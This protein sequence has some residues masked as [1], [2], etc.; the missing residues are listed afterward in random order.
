[1]SNGLYQHS[2]GQRLCLWK[3][4]GLAKMR[5]V[6][7]L[8]SLGDSETIAKVKL[9]NLVGSHEHNNL[10]SVLCSLPTVYC[11]LP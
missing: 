11:L 10:S 6:R 8:V 2:Q 3:R 4:W 9:W 5:V 1:M 7:E